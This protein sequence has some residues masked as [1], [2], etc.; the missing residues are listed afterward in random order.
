MIR[1]TLIVLFVFVAVGCGNQQESA[2]VTESTGDTG[3]HSD[4]LT[5]DHDEGDAH[6]HADGTT[7]D[8]DGGGDGQGGGGGDGQGGG[9]GG[10]QGGGGGGGQGGGGG[11]GQGGGKGGGRSFNLMD[12]DSDGDGKV[13]K[14]E[15]PERLQAFFDRMDPNGDGF[16]DAE[17]MAAMRERFGGGGRRG[18][19]QGGGQGRRQG[20]GDGKGKGDSDGQGGGRRLDLMQYD[21][22]GD[23]KI[24][25][26][27]M[28]KRLLPFFDRMDPNGDGF[29][30]AEEIAA[31]RQRRGISEDADA[32]TGDDDAEAGD[33][34]AETG[35]DDA[36]TGD[37]D[38]ETG[39]ADAETGDADA[40]T[41]SAVGSDGTDD[42]SVDS[43]S[44]EAVSAG[45]VLGFKFEEGLKRGLEVRQ[46]SDQTLTI[47]GQSLDTKSTTV[48]SFDEIMGRDTEG[49]ISVTQENKS[50]VVNSSFPGG[51][52]LVFDSANPQLTHNVPQLQALLEV[53]NARSHSNLTYFLDG[54]KQ[55]I[56]VKGVD[57]MTEGLSGA[58][59][60]LLKSEVETSQLLKAFNEEH[61]I[62]PEQ[63]VQVDETWT[64][65]QRIGLGQG[66]YMTLQIEYTARGEKQHGEKSRQY[67]DVQVQKVTFAHEGTSDAPLQIVSSDLSVQS[68]EG[69]IYFDTERGLVS[70]S[71]LKFHVVGAMNFSAN[72]QELPGKLDLQIGIHTLPR[73][74]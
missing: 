71:T 52:D 37:A 64:R 11:D 29:I 18:G 62:F 33:A 47:A 21:A 10:G 5:H 38:A 56:D 40:E 61:A 68:S 28:P 1:F 25:V 60:D 26:K 63:P 70:E 43:E 67:V 27:E 13:S 12:Y 31:A 69:N 65:N 73:E 34:D 24:D 41:Q 55:A 57:A 16:I 45:I 32:E 35:D 39:D 9:G 22:D 36:E 59:L 6:S 7:H 17:E 20:G 19:G 4:G 54:D 46:T 8:H 42:V 51:I 72:G 15:A 3:D 48:A 14:S 30:D 49:R 58:S 74:E 66:Q 23:G 44:T 50:L 53:W 2:P